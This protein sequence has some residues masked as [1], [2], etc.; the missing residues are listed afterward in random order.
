[1]K[2]TH[3]NNIISKISGYTILEAVVAFLVLMIFFI[4][5]SSLE[6]VAIHS[7]K[8]IQRKQAA[9]IIC[10]AIFEEV[11]SNGIPYNKEP[12]PVLKGV[13]TIGSVE[14]KWK[15]E[16]SD[17]GDKPKMGRYLKLVRVT[18]RWPTSKGKG[19]LIRETRIVLPGVADPS[20]TPSPTHSPHNLKENNLK[21]GENDAKSEK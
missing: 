3:S 7:T 19:F 17:I 21:S 12:E 14:Y 15:R 10:S 4:A 20:P 5:I 18:V 2:K 1:M 16:V 9:E 8:S 11:R 6:V 13:A